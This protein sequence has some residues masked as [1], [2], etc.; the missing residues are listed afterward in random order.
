MKLSTPRMITFWIA[1]ILGLL[2]VVA[3]FIHHSTYAFG[4]A[5][6]GLIVLVLGNLLK[7]L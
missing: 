4:L 6:L 7:S 2:G 5:L 1:I 3:Y